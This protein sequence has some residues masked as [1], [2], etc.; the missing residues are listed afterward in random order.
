MESIRHQLWTLCLR[1]K[2][3]DKL[4]VKGNISDGHNPWLE[5]V[6]IKKKK[7]AHINTHLVFSL[8]KMVVNLHL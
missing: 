1:F 3:L 8:Y 4:Q 5:K 2:E 6:S 7:H